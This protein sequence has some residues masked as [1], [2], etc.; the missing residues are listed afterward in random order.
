MHHLGP[1]SFA[2]Y[3]ALGH[4]SERTPRTRESAV[5]LRQFGSSDKAE[6]APARRSSHRGGAHLLIDLPETKPKA[7]IVP[8]VEL[9]MAI[10]N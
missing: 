2:S 5:T 9:L 6:G 4:H 10:A 8:C 1:A 7:P 3:C